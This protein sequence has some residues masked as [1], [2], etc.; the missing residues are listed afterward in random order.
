MNTVIHIKICN[1]VRSIIRKYLLLWIYLVMF[2]FYIFGHVSSDIFGHAYQNIFGLV[3]PDLIGHVPLYILGRFP[4]VIDIF[5]HVSQ[6]YLG[7]LGL[8]QIYN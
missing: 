3:P 6:Q 2:L 7:K 5:G 1:R 4:P 8:L